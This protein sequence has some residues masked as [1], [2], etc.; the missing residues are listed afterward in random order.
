MAQIRYCVRHPDPDIPGD[1][2]EAAVEF[3]Q[4]ILAALIESLPPR[5]SFPDET[6]TIY[7]SAGG[8][9]EVKARASDWISRLKTAYY[10]IPQEDREDFEIREDFIF[11][12]LSDKSVVTIVSL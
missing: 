2:W 7:F 3:P 5:V 11:W 8:E 4:I 1:S 10:G 9:A 6:V 12:N